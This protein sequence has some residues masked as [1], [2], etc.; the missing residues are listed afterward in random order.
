MHCSDKKAQQY[1]KLQFAPSQTFIIFAP[2]SERK[3]I[4][5]SY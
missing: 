5:Y 4:Q 3:I 1:D 2:F